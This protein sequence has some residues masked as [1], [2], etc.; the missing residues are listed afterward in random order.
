ML[1]KWLDLIPTNER[2]MNYFKK[3]QRTLKS[4]NKHAGPKTRAV[5]L[6][7]VNSTSVACDV[8]ALVLY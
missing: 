1:S 4:L 5:C 8:I 7:P 6:E 3:Y 2:F